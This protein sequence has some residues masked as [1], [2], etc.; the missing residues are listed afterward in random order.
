MLTVRA[1]RL[2]L[3]RVHMMLFVFTL[4]E[5]RHGGE[6]QDDASPRVLRG[7]PQDLQGGKKT[8]KSHCD[9]DVISATEVQMG[10]L[11]SVALPKEALP[12]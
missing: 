12:P 6:A 2:A 3:M 11:P 8:R 1:P 5:E 7:R 4:Q 9:P 10:A